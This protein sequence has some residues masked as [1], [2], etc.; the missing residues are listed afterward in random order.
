MFYL[1]HLA[2]E[3]ET[4]IIDEPELNLHPDNQRKIAIILVMIA[5]RGIKVIVST[6]S[7]YF[8]R[9]INNL[10]MLKNEFPSKNEIMQNY[11]YSE[12]MLISDKQ[13]NAYLFE[14]NSIKLME[15]DNKE[16]IIAKTFDDVINSL[17]SSSDDIYYQSK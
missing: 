13:V 4:L 3:G 7:D 9:E 10:I 6:H 1:E 15:M 17:N 12:N 16:G 5:N 8:I 11:G 2:K 14:N